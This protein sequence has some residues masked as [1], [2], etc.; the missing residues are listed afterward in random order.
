MS[1]QSEKIAAIVKLCHEIAQSV[2]KMES[3]QVSPGLLGAL[4]EILMQAR[5]LVDDDNE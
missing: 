3:K 5:V 4:L 1:Q 2:E